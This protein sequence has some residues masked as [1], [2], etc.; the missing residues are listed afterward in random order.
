[1]FLRRMTRIS[2]HHP[3]DLRSP[4]PATLPSPDAAR[5]GAPGL[6]WP[7]LLGATAAAVAVSGCT[8]ATTPSTPDGS[9]SPEPPA[10]A[11]ALAL[12]PPI[13]AAL[14][15]TGATQ[16][17]INLARERLVAR[18]MTKLGFTYP[19]V[20][21]ARSTDSGSRPMPFGL[22]S[23]DRPELRQTEAPR[24]TPGRTDPPY[25]RALFGDEGK[26]VS[27][28]GTRVS[29][30]RPATGCVAEA[31]QRLLGADRQRW[32][33]LRIQFYE[34]ELTARHKLDAD[35]AFRS[36]NAKWATCMARS[37]Y[38]LKDPRQLPGT[39]PAEAD[40][41]NQPLAQADLACKAETEYFATAYTRLAEMQRTAL[42]GNP[43]AIRDWSTLLDRQMSV[44]RTLGAG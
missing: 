4:G 2:R 15:G 31:E 33:T 32:I 34:A 24:P 40:L 25:V 14:Y 3:G 41:R 23:L 22:E 12:R 7:L 6:R 42:A 18:C 26:R 39:L 8:A 5:A 37:R 35:P 20:P 11:P 16:L 30:A 19:M 27:A 44:A 43:R 13:Y 1:M 38:H 9:P 17:K 10:V 29:V 36:L 28:R 21:A